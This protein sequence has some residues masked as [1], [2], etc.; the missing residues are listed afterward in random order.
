MDI[1]IIEQRLKAYTNVNIALDLKSLSDNQKTII[2][3]L[4]EAGKIADHIFWQQTS[5]DAMEIREGYKNNPG[6]LKEY[7][8]IN[9]GPY[10]RLNNFQRFVGE[11]PDLKPPGAGFYPDD[12]SQENFLKY[13]NQNPESKF[14]HTNYI[15]CN[16]LFSGRKYVNI[17]KNMNL[18]YH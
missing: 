4:V 1:S 13:I 12:L 16:N 14:I 9:Y 17:A 7:I 5:H 15:I 11:G 18:K 8:E 2:E 10:D 6:P 3:N